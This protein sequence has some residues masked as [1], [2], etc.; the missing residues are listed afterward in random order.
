MFKR[1]L[2]ERVR[3]ILNA[4]VGSYIRN[5]EPVGSRTLS[6]TLGL[7]LSPAT[8]RNVMADL[9]EQGYLDQPHTSAGRVP[10]DKAY[11]YYVDT[12]VSHSKLPHAVKVMIDDVL[13]EPVGSLEKTLAE[14]SK[15]LA[16]LTSFTCVVAAPKVSTTRLKLVEFIRVSEQRIF[17]VLITQSN[18]VYNKIIE[19]G[20]DLSQEFL[21]SVSQ[22][23]NEQFS[24]QSLSDIRNR[25]LESLME[26]KEQYDRLLAQVVRLSKKAFEF[27][28]SRELYVEG[29]FNILKTMDDMDSIR[30]LLETLDEKISILELLDQTL[31]EGGVN[32]FIGVENEL[33]DLRQF[34]IVTANYGNGA[35]MLGSLG[36]IGPTRMDYNRVVPIIDYTAKT[37]SES[38]ANQ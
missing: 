15:L 24:E 21:N 8:I 5:T 9:T 35:N 26:E 18:M 32:I 28:E 17:V 34:S 4:I 29:Q 23:L 19:V 2:E 36:V 12:V 1:E 14:T 31:T 22:Y 13:G 27:S 7:E 20:E 10:T 16:L 11:R 37:L 3:A 33:E 38:I 6:K 30:K 25:M